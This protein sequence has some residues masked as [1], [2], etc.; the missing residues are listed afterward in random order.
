MGLAL[1]GFAL[2]LM[3]PAQSAMNHRLRGAVSSPWV[4]A[5]IS[6]MVGTGCL[7][8]VAWFTA[9]NLPLDLRLVA[10]QPWWLFTGGALGVLGMTTTVLLLPVIGALYSTMLNLTAQVMTTMLVDHF[11]F[12]GVQPYPVD[13]WRLSGAGIVVVAAA[14]AVLGHGGAPRSLRHHVSGWWWVAGLATG[15]C[16]GLQVAINGRLAGVLGSAVHSALVSFTVGTI[17]LVLLTVVTRASWRLRVPSGQQRNPW[18]M[19]AGGLLGALYVTGVA[20][21]APLIGSALTVVVIQLGIMTGSLVVD[22]FG[23]L[24]APKRAVRP[25]AVIGLLLMMCGVLV[26]DAPGI[27][28]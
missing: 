23:L 2:G 19:W 18:W 15:V 24:S 11:G 9:S 27:L 12:F 25:R 16:F 20:F 17:L 6:F 14:L 28:R 7:A 26:M 22:R 13:G 10:G 21:L 5:A 3:L 1:V 8:L 4:M